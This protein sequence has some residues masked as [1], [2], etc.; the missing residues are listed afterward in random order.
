MCNKGM[1][2][3]N[4]N[5]VHTFTNAFVVIS[6]DQNQFLPV[7]YLFYYNC[8]IWQVCQNA[9]HKRKKITCRIKGNKE[10]III[11]TLAVD[12]VGNFTARSAFS[13]WL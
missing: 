2:K 7:L 1:L 5:F 11:I 13:V 12:G 6:L 9:N 10:E 4:S 8:V 3:G